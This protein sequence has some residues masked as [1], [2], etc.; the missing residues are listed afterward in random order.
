M[1]S[2]KKLFF[3]S[4]APLA[5]LCMLLALTEVA[6]RA[7]A[8]ALGNPFV[9]P[10][11]RDD[12]G[13]Y[14]INRGYLQKY[15]PAT[16]TAVPEFKPSLM[17]QHK[18]E[19]AFRVLCIGESSMFG[20]PYAMDATIPAILRKQLRHICPEREI[21]VINLGAAAINSNVVLDITKHLFELQP[22]LILLYV[23]HN[24]FYGPDGVGA[25]LLERHFP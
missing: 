15:F 10:M 17:K 11:S 3:F 14:M 7:F 5:F 20:T 24:E 12:A 25:S 2:R 18:A 22:D 9:S 19:N 23:G 6:L 1:A 13:W 16:V 4:I 21:E 8:P